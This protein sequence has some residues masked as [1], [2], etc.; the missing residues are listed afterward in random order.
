VTIAVQSE[1]VSLAGWRAFGG[2]SGAP[3]YRNVVE[4][5]I[6]RDFRGDNSIVPELATSWERVDDR[7]IRFYLREGVAFHDG[8]S[9]NAESAAQVINY[10]MSEELNSDLLDFVGAP[11]SAV[12]VD[13]Y[14]IDVS[15][16]DPDPILLSKMYFVGITSAKQLNEALDTYDTNLIGTGPY[17]LVGWNAGAGIDYTVNPDWW[18]HGNPWAARGS[19][20][21]ENLHYV[22]RAEEQVRAAMVEAGEANIGVW[23]TSEQCA[24]LGGCAVAASVETIFIR[25]DTH[26]PMFSDIRVREA[27]HLAI[28]TQAIIDTILSGEAT[29]A[30]QICNATCTG[31]DSS[32]EP[33]PY[34]PDRAVALLAEAEAAGVPVDM[35]INLAAR[36]AV[37]PR[38]E[39]VVQAVQAML[40]DVGFNVSVS[41]Y[42]PETFGQMVVQNWKDVSEDRNLVI[43]HGHGNE[44]FDMA[45][46]YKYY[47]SCEGILSVYCNEEA[48]ALWNEALPLEGDARQNKLVE[49][50]NVLHGDWGNGY[51]GHQDLAYGV[52]GIDW[53]PSL[54]HTILAK[55]FGNIG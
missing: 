4:F 46:S 31:H 2:I 11:M 14:T 39:E 48:E 36:E 16:P 37:F 41:F 43:I 10:I 44:I 34:D 23:L 26:G 12:A 32:L 45:T 35:E 18:G 55:Q 6:T 30:A 51:I 50:N 15:T 3:G 28:D 40:T 29:I 24:G 42:D 53:E 9:L 7:T 27:F 1:P 49:M 47:F 21:V 52:Q 33:Y 25:P 13:E 22:F 54:A 17:Q 20:S 19:V 38:S 8:S 5:L